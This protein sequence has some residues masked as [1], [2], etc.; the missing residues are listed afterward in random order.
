MPHVKPLYVYSFAYG[1]LSDG[2]SKFQAGSGW[3]QVGWTSRDRRARAS[4]SGTKQTARQKAYD[5]A[6]KAAQAS[7]LSISSVQY[8]DWVSG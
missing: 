1:T 7:N 8:C 2:K 6:V 5:N 3:M 4:V